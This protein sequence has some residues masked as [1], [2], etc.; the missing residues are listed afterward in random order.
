M[1]INHVGDVAYELPANALALCVYKFVSLKGHY[2]PATSV[3][4]LN[5][6]HGSINAWQMHVAVY[7]ETTL[8]Q[9]LH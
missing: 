7:V 3:G 4:L 6:P 9:Y 5:Q 8:A 1:Q 2:D